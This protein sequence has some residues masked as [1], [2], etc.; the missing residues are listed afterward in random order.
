M[1]WCNVNA[2]S[3]ATWIKMATLKFQRW[4]DVLLYQRARSQ[5]FHSGYHIDR[6]SPPCLR[7]I[8][9]KVCCFRVSQPR[10]AFM[11]SSLFLVVDEKPAPFLVTFA[12]IV[13]DPAYML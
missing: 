5:D 1:L 9:H 3:Q 7:P 6:W 12:G 2:L 10:F 13:F 8:E 4:L 11:L